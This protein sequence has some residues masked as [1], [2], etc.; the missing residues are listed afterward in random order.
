MCRSIDLSTS[1][2]RAM[3][4]FHPGM[5]FHV[6]IKITLSYKCFITAL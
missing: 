3:E 1:C 6:F 5:C 4:W 2:M